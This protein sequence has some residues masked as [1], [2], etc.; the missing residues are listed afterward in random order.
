[1]KWT[2][3]QK[4]VAKKNVPESTGAFGAHQFGGPQIAKTIQRKG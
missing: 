4:A 1:M 2:F 3:Q